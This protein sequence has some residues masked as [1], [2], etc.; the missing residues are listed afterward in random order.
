MNFIRPY[1]HL[2]AIL[3][4]LLSSCQ[5]KDTPLDKLQLQ[6][7]I[8]EGKSY[9]LVSNMSQKVLSE[10][11]NQTKNLKNVLSIDTSIVPGQKTADGN[12]TLEITYKRVSLTITALDSAVHWDSSTSLEPPPAARAYWALLGETFTLVLD[13]SGKPTAVL[14]IDS[15]LDNIFVKLKLDDTAKSEPIKAGLRQRFSEESILE[16]FRQTF[17][18]YP[19]HP[20]GKGDSWNNSNV[21][22]YSGGV[23]ADTSWTLKEQKKERLVIEIKGL[24]KSAAGKNATSISNLSGNQ[25]GQITVDPSTGL[26]LEIEIHQALAGTLSP[27][28]KAS[29]PATLSITSDFKMT[30]TEIMP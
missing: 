9:S 25:S 5:S 21:L 7:K 2:F 4:L 28:G 10:K 12:R 29:T 19:D 27:S 14:G 22:K 1:F 15:A 30:I 13:A 16:S 18:F 17:G 24:L 3:L 20:V 8:P 6:L 26:P 23:Q 11:D